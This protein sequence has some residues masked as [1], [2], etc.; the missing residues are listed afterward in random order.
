MSYKH[1]PEMWNVPL[2]IE[3]I[4]EAKEHQM[5]CPTCM[6]KT[7]LNPIK[8]DREIVKALIAA[9]YQDTIKSAEMEARFGRGVGSNYAKLKHWDLIEPAEGN[10]VWKITELGRAFLRGEVELPETLWIY[11]DKPRLVRE[12]MYTGWVTIEYLSEGKEITRESAAA[13][14]VP[15][16]VSPQS[17]LL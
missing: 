2:G 6:R 3:S 13:E 17:S 16:N 10:G 4:F 5:E 14:S 11:D 8:L 9:A 15:I 12:A 7:A 1:Y